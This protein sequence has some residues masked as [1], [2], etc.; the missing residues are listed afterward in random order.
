MVRPSLSIRATG[1]LK[2]CDSRRGKWSRKLESACGAVEG[3]KELLGSW[4]QAYHDCGEPRSVTSSAKESVWATVDSWLVLEVC[5]IVVCLN[6]CPFSMHMNPTGSNKL[7]NLISGSYWASPTIASDEKDTC[8]RTRRVVFSGWL[9][10]N[11]FQ[12]KVASLWR[13][14]WIETWRHFSCNSLSQNNI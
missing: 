12:E 8:S 5:L 10:R 11:S 3:K 9:W 4:I 6:A 13:H 1:W 2:Y 7:N 14:F